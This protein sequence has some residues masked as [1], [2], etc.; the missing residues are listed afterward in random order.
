MDHLYLAL[1]GLLAGLSGG[2]LGIGGS[3][4]MIPGMNVLFGDH[5]HLHQ[6]AAMIVNFFVV[7]PAAYQHARARAIVWPV[8]RG[9][10]PAAVATVVVGVALSETSLF[11]GRNEVYLAG[12]FGLFMASVGFADL[13]RLVRGGRADA[14]QN[15]PEVPSWRSALLV[16][17]PT[18]LV[19][20]LLGVGGGIM[21]VPLQRR[22]L[23]IPLR[24]A[25]ANSATTIIPL[26]LVGACIKNYAVISD[27][28]DPWWKSLGLAAVLIPTAMCAAFAGGKL[29]HTLPLRHIR[30]AFILLLF[31][32]AVR[33]CYPAASTL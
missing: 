20:G 12:L 7:V 24:M 23:R 5:Q 29:T 8:V 19:A 1:I 22:I 6:A 28:V 14:V 18:G 16:G 13:L 10:A 30:I 21:M 3:I 31:A 25:I 26:S 15:A 11:A 2:L 27:G 33:M 32:V 9:M 4:V 17:I